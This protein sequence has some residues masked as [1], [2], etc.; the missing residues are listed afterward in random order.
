MT[1]RNVRD[2]V[3]AAA[4]IAA[5]VVTA[6]TGIEAQRR[7]GG[8]PAG[9]RQ[10]GAPASPMAAAPIDLTGYWVAVVTE[11][12]RWRMLTPPKGDVSSIPLNAEGQRAANAWDPAAPLP[13]GEECRPYGAAGVMRLPTRL[14]ITWEN[15]TT[16]KLDTDAG[17]QTR[18]L[19]FGT[20]PAP[21]GAPQWQ[22][23]SLAHWESVAEGEM[24]SPTTRARALSGI[25]PDALSGSLRVVTTRMRPGYLR[26]NGV[27]YSGDAVLH[28]FFDRMSAPNGDEWL[29]VTSRLEDPKYLAQP[30][31]LSTHF[32]REP[33]ASKWNPRPC[34]VIPPGQ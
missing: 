11:D 21:A 2:L 12:W 32:K 14:H 5:L 6:T 13:K 9:A 15:E 27:P 33:D 23:F 22:G 7:G 31:T 19:F 17:E 16:L 1:A 28:E 8:T 20:R 26:R 10:G 25:N 34:E 18:R 3:C 29:V 24:L 4:L 30:F